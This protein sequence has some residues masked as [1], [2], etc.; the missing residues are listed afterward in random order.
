MSWDPQQRRFAL[1]A[2]A[3]AAAIALAWVTEWWVSEHGTRYEVVVRRGD[4]VLAVYDLDDMRALPQ[5][6]VKALGKVETGPTLLSVLEES[7][8]SRFETLQVLGAG[9]RDDGEVVLSSSEVTPGV[10]LDIAERGTVKVV[11]PDMTWDDRVR[12]VTDIVVEGGGQ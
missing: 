5:S 11:G 8:V 2:A 12:D 9:V 10:L 3:L 1:V 4:A 7:G 6:T